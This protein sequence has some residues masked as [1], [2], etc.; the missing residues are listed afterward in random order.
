MEKHY[1]KTINFNI[2]IKVNGIIIKNMV[3]VFKKLNLLYIKD[4][5]NIIKNMD[6]DH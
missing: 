6:M 4:Y 3:K 2:H 1:I 5:G